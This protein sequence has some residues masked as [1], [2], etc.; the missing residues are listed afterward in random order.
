MNSDEFWK[1]K[2]RA[3]L[4]DPPD[5]VFELK[6]HEKRRIKEILG[7]LMP[8]KS[9][10]RKIKTADTQASSLQRIDLEKSKDGKELRS[11]FD[12]VHDTEK[13]EYIGYPVIRHPVTG[14]VKEF[15]V[16]AESLPEV[17]KPVINVRES[18]RDDY[19]KKFYSLLDRILEVEKETFSKLVKSGGSKEDYLRIWTFYEDELKNALKSEFSESFAEEFVNLP[20]YTLSPDHTLFDHADATSAIYG[21]EC[22]GRKPVLLLF[23]LNPVQKFIANSRK[24]K[25]LW[26]ASHILAALTFSAICA[27]VEKFGPDAVIYPH[28]RSNPFFRAWI[29]SKGIHDSKPEPKTLSAATVPN[30]FFAI[31]GI[32]NEGELDELEKEVSENVNGMLEELFD[33]VWS[34]VWDGVVA[35]ISKKLEE[36]I[37]KCSDEKRKISLENELKEVLEYRSNKK[38]LHREILLSHF[39]S[40]LSFLKVP[41]IDLS[42]DKEDAYA[43]L[44][45][46]VKSLNLPK[47]IERKN[48]GWLEM[49]EKVEASDNKPSKY[50]LYSLYYEILLELNAIKSAKFVKPAEPSGFKCTL[51]GEHLAI[52]GESEQFMK[53]LW[54]KIH[55]ELP[56]Y[57][58][59]NERLCAM[60]LVKRFYPKFLRELELFE[61][62]DSKEIVPKT[63]SVSEVAM[64]KNTKAGI[65]WKDIYDHLR[66]EKNLD[67][68]LSGVATEKH[69][70]L[71]AK[72]KELKSLIKK[73]IANVEDQLKKQPYSDVFLKNLHKNFSNEVLYIENLRDTKSLLDTLGFKTL[74]SV[75]IDESLLSEV[76]DKLSEISRLIEEEPPKYYAILVMDGDEMGKLL[77]GD[78]LLAT[79][80]YLHPEVLK[81]VGDDLKVKAENVKRLVTPAAH[82]A[83]SK[84]VMNFAVNH[85]FEIVESNR[86]TLIYAGGDDVLALLPVDTALN[87]AIELADTFS[88]SWSGWEILLGGTISVGILIVHYRHPLY[89][90]LDKARSLLEKA[91]DLGRNSVAVGL[92]KRSGSYYEAVANY[93]TVSY[94]KAIA[95]LIAENRVSPRVLYDLM[96]VVNKL[97]GE[98]ELMQI[99][100][101]EATRHAKENDDARFFVSLFSNGVS[102]VRV[103]FEEINGIS[104]QVE[105]QKFVN[106][107][108][109]KGRVRELKKSSGFCGCDAAYDFVVKKQ[110]MGFLSLVKIVFDAER[111]DER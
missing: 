10:K 63:E 25:D 110:A 101:Y 15:C 59:E 96:S 34:E 103:E 87:T 98:D 73:L 45:E 54:K 50:D 47:D 78:K 55:R 92:L 111:G 13:Y 49:L 37:E 58:R 19:E 2:I 90:A 81:K 48:L 36:E 38:E 106:E 39:N 94:V 6:T 8:S 71:K 41:E 95:E 46:F 30:K 66:D 102:G 9:I 91:K 22:N 85:V 26:A 97:P 11:T 31:V 40:T 75:N 1:N 29:F 105:F 57:L 32:E 44:K 79:A 62:I 51:C 12:K 53:E 18:E 65:A 23:K 67:K 69:E 109:R 86:G 82:A 88:K 68:L 42:G 100:K 99:V 14:E 108:V 70:N 20:A 104:N 80:N 4:H 43:K 84:A 61:K 35:K 93:E 33:S 89:D 60:C 24:E 7:N 3:F 5:K 21:A 76:R 72:L 77:S 56:G 74:D 27:I 28:L 52:G 17:D 83:I 107:L 64:C 16:I